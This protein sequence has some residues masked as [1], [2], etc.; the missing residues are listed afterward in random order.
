M[1]KLTP[2]EEDYLETIY[3]LSG[4][5]GA[6]RITDVAKARNVTVPTARA[7]VARFIRYGLVSKEPYGKILLEPEGRRLAAQV[8]AGHRVLLRWLTDVLLLDRESAERDACRMEH[9]LSKKTLSRLVLLLEAVEKCSGSEPG[10]LGMFR[11][12]VEEQQLEWK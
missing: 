11:R 8:Y 6:A 3:R 10:C 12:A 5:D 4:D 1:V 7:A 2:R 9:G